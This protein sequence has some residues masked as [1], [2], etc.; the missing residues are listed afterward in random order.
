[1]SHEADSDLDLTGWLCT[2]LPR[3]TAEAAE[4]RWRHKLDAA[5]AAIRTGTPVAPALADQ[6]LPIDLDAARREQVCISRGDPAVLNEFNIDPVHVTG[7]YA[8]PGEPGCSRRAQPDADGH[9]PRC[10]VH[11]LTMILH[12]RLAPGPPR[13][14]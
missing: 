10:G 1:M 11:D 9:E 6:N 14:D 2:H 8:C 4:Y 3:L 5:L 13:H 7:D 12:N